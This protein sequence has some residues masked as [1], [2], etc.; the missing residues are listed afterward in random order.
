MENF[1]RACLYELLQ[2][3]ARRA[4]EIPTVNRLKTKHINLYSA[5][6]SR[7]TVETHNQETFQE[8][9]MSLFHLIKRRTWRE[10]RTITN[11]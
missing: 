7:G 11:V 5:R 2:Y 4:E 1:Y 10:Q 6:L 3:P 9:R 8:E